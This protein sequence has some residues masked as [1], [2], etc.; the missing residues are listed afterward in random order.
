M[1]RPSAAGRDWRRLAGTV[2]AQLFNQIVTLA[3]QLLLVPILLSAWGIDRY[4]AWLLLSV[5]PTYLTLSDLGFT[6]IAKNEMAMSMVRGD[7]GAVLRTYHSVAL[8]LLTI[9]IVVMAVL[10][11][12]VAGV[13][14][15][16]LWPLAQTSEG[17]AGLTLL[18]LG[19]VVIVF[20]F[21]LLGAA[22][23]RCIGR[24]AEEV[25]WGAAARFC[26][27]GAAGGA[28]LAGGGFVEAAGAMLVIRVALTGALFLRLR[29][30]APWLTPW[31]AH[32]SM[33]DVRR[34]FGP[35]LSYMCYV[36]GSAVTVQGPVLALG[37]IGT[38]RDVAIF[39]ATRTLTRLGV[40]ASN[41]LSFSVAPEYSR[42]FGAGQAGRFDALVRL[43]LVVVLGGAVAYAG[44][45]AWL[46]D[47][48]LQRWTSG[49]VEVIQPFFL[50]MLAMVAC[51]MVWSTLFAPLAATNRH[52]AASQI[53]LAISLIGLAI[54]FAIPGGSALSGIGL[55]FAATN[56]M[57]IGVVAWLL[58]R[59]GR[60]AA[61]G[62][63]SAAVHVEG[64]VEPGRAQ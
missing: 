26:E 13:R 38:A 8:L 54:C 20:Q 46:G 34:L 41:V 57:M 59:Q 60:G 5:V 15:T 17:E 42:L 56:L 47:W 36:A 63:F 45:L 51:E 19:G 35:S 23:L 21:M 50:F 9:A 48:A 7:R 28:A 33:G 64:A 6:A 4:G 27:A 30:L 24:P 12:F 32:W 22:G 3:T 62:G 14:L 49:H 16:H 43:S 1:N 44:L 2:G 25:L 58:A 29:R 37:S 61:S 11:L 10:A 39:S 31:G 55:V 40:A 18:I 53:Y 52:E